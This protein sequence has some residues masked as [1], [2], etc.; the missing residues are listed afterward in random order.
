ML[1][2]LQLSF[3]SSSFFTSNVLYVFG[4]WLLTGK[5]TSQKLF[6][7]IDTSLFKRLYGDQHEPVSYHMKMRDWNDDDEITAESTPS[8]YIATSISTSISTS[9]TTDAS[10]MSLSELSAVLP[11][12]PRKSSL[13]KAKAF[14][15]SQRR[16][17]VHTHRHHHTHRQTHHKCKKAN[18]QH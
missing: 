6:E 11:Y 2:V 8:T 10:N 4:L 14:P 17:T 7:T 13:S 1:F 3:V 15:N 12:E 18:G 16:K 5:H 9:A